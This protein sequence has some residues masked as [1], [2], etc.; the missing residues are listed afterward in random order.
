MT[1]RAAPTS[2]PSPNPVSP[3]SARKRR[4]NVVSPPFPPKSARNRGERPRN[5]TPPPVSAHA[6]PSTPECQSEKP[7][8][9]TVAAG[10]APRR[11]APR[12]VVVAAAAAAA[13]AA[14]RAV[15]TRQHGGVALVG[16]AHARVAVSSHAG[17][18]FVE[19]HAGV[20]VG[21]IG[22][23]G[24]RGGGEDEGG[25]RGGEQGDGG[26][27]WGGYLLQGAS[28]R[29]EGRP[30]TSSAETCMHVAGNV[31]ILRAAEPAPPK[32]RG[33]QQLAQSSAP[34]VAHSVDLAHAVARAARPPFGAFAAE[35]QHK[36]PVARTVMKG[37][38]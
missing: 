32:G 21:L 9:Q 35:I 37:L 1:Q 36:S 25:Q 34:E 12:A 22:P 15:I 30:S 7:Q 17:R 31:P 24:R 29:R 18:P 16:C 3:V 38:P 19:A 33:E 5:G 27:S 8:R 2:P 6:P 23:R 10:R 4:P 11:A 26:T 28:E 14:G 13:R 20:L